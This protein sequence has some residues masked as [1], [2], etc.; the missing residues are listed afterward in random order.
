[1]IAS[2]PKWVRCSSVLKNK[3]VGRVRASPSSEIIR[4]GP[5][6]WRT[7]MAELEVPKS[8]PRE[9]SCKRAICKRS[10]DKAKRC[11]LAQRKKNRHPGTAWPPEGHRHRDA[12][13]KT[14]SAR[15]K[16]KALDQQDQG[17]ID[18]TIRPHIETR[19]SPA[20]RRLSTTHSACYQA[21]RQWLQNACRRT[22]AHN[23]S[24]MRQRP[25]RVAF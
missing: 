5:L 3:A 24:R 16:Q 1:V 14:E 13:E 6:P 18:Q 19:Y 17:L 2:R 12:P 20:A 4:A 21:A 15:A 9:T 8:I 7:D 11:A 10:E 23:S 25:A 22:I